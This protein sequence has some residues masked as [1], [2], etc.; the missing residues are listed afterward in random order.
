[1][2]KELEKEFDNIFWENKEFVFNIARKYFD[3]VESEDILQEVFI[4]VYVNY[5]SFRGDSNIKTWIYRITVNEIYKRLKK[6][7][8]E[9]EMPNIE[10][11]RIEIKEILDI[12]NTMPEKRAKVMILRGIDNLDYQ[13]VSKIIGISVE[14]AKNLYSLGV[15]DF[16]QKFFGQEVNK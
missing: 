12:I 9:I 14:S 5:K 6:K 15:K 7:K 3:D 8:R 10:S 16:R 2:K 4:K 13:T 11:N 1:M